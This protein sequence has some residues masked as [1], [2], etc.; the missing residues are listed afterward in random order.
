MN[1]EP[2]EHR[3]I[4]NI[5]VFSN[6]TFRF[7]R[8]RT[9]AERKW[10]NSKWTKQNKC[11]RN[12]DA[13][14]GDTPFTLEREL[15]LLPVNRYCFGVPLLTTPATCFQSTLV[16]PH[17]RVRENL[18]SH[19]S[20]SLIRMRVSSKKSFNLLKLKQTQKHT[21]SP[22]LLLKF[23]STHR[24][25][26]TSPALFEFSIPIPG[27]VLASKYAL[28]MSS[29][30]FLL[31]WPCGPSHQRTRD[32]ATCEAS[33][34]ATSSYSRHLLTAWKTARPGQN[35]QRYSLIDLLLSGWTSPRL[36]KFRFYRPISP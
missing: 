8:R 9:Q 20:Q 1:C 15:A 29:D 25:M 10:T 32:K 34:Q 11:R 16:V 17:V 23:F 3:R 31:W 7:L 24:S 21:S 22:T 30:S 5:D 33:P 19:P 28:L 14:D 36:G 27:V 2:V 35:V 12:D 4:Q 6:R 26:S 18:V 13:I